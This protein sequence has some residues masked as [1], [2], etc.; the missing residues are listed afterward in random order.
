MKQK[1]DI[2]LD[3]ALFE[4]PVFEESVKERTLSQKF[5]VAI[6]AILG[7]CSVII[8]MTTPLF[9][10]FIWTRLFGFYGFSSYLLYLI[11]FL[12]SVYRAIKIGFLK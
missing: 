1:R 11:G 12:A 6:L 2:D 9:I 7:G 4:E 3:K 8:E 5:I 10:V